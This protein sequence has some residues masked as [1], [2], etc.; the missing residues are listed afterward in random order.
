LRGEHQVHNAL[1][2][3]RVLEAARGAG[4]DVPDAAIR[5]G[6]ETVEWPARLELLTLTNGRQVLL[7]AAHNPEGARALRNH[8]ARW[9]PERPSLLVGIMRDKDA[10]AILQ[11]LLPVTSSVIATAADTRR[12]MPA[13]QLAARV[14]ALDPEKAVRACADVLTAVDAALDASR[15]VCVAGS[16]VLVGAVRDALERRGILH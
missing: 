3:V 11:E 10:D 4:L 9:Y 2:T 6:L 1:V 12:A 15:T 14:L 5:E 7:D 13:D 8:L 16:I